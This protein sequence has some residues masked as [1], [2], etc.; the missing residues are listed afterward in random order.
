M[1]HI[2]N[3]LNVLPQDINKTQSLVRLPKTSEISKY[4]FIVKL[5]M[6]KNENG[7]KTSRFMASARQ[8]QEESF[9][10]SYNQNDLWFQLLNIPNSILEFRLNE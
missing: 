8:G 3:P 4:G 7:A 1:K 10:S 5:L 6:E 9:L 2:I